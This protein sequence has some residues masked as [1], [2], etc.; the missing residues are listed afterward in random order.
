[1]LG[2]TAQLCHN[3]FVFPQNS[4]TRNIEHAEKHLCWILL[5]ALLEAPCIRCEQPCCKDAT[6]ILHMDLSGKKISGLQTARATSFERKLLCRR[7]TA[8]I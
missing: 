6:Y 4:T 8:N 3:E 1:M 2:H 7:R 5:I